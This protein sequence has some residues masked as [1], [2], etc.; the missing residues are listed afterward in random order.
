MLLCYE[1]SK[2]RKH[3]TWEKV[4]QGKEAQWSQ[5]LGMAFQVIH[6]VLTVEA[7]SPPKQPRQYQL[8]P[9]RTQLGLDF[10]FRMIHVWLSTCF[11]YDVIREYPG[12]RKASWEMLHWYPEALSWWCFLFVC[13]AFVFCFVFFGCVGS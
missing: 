7:H 12:V 4:L 3:R 11:S 1:M 10:S 8:I 2:Q 9:A 13:F 5:I 6:H